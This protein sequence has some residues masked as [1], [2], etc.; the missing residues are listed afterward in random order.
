MIGTILIFGAIAICSTLHATE[1]AITSTWQTLCV[2][3]TLSSVDWISCLSVSP[4]SVRLAVSGLQP[5]VAVTLVCLWLSRGGATCLTLLVIGWRILPQPACHRV[6]CTV[7]L[8]I[9]VF[10]HHGI[11]PAN[12][13]ISSLA[14]YLASSSKTSH[15]RQPEPGLK[16]MLWH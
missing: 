8:F 14:C 11:G 9:V 4:G 15:K 16:L 5:V 3:F 7:T 2:T 12:L 6:E 10:W 1:I 13:C